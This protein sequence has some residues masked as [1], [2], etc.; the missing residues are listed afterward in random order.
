MKKPPRVIAR[1]GFSKIGL[2]EKIA[3]S[4]LQEI[5]LTIR[6]YAGPRAH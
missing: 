2:I 6:D 3:K 5:R 1:N 4:F